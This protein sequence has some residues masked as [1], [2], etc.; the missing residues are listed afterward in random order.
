MDR[1]LAEF[2]QMLV[3]NFFYLRSTESFR[4]KWMLNS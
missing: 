1:Q 2:N 3:S 4:G